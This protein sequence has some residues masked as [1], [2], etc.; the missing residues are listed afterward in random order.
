MTT[1]D[2]Q[3][4]PRAARSTRIPLYIS[5]GLVGLL[6]VLYFL[7]VRQQTEYFEKRNLRLL[8]GLTQQLNTAFETQEAVLRSWAGAHELP[9]A[10]RA[11]L[12]RDFDPVPCTMRALSG[13]DAARYQDLDELPGK[14]VVVRKLSYQ[15]GEIWLDLA[16]DGIIT[17]RSGIWTRP[18]DYV[19]PHE[20][21]VLGTPV[22]RK[23]ALSKILD[24]VMNR[25]IFGMFDSVFLASADG[26]VLYSIEPSHSSST[27]LWASAAPEH[28]LQ[29]GGIASGELMLAH[30]GAA[31]VRLGWRKSEPLSPSIL[32]DAGRK[33]PV[34]VSGRSYELFTQ[35][36]LFPRPEQKSGEPAAGDAWLVGG[37]VSSARLGADTRAVSATK[38]AFAIALCAIALCAWPFLQI[39]LKNERQPLTMADVILVS[40]CTVAGLMMLTL[41][42]L[43]WLTYMRL[44]DSADAQLRQFSYKLDRD[45]HRNLNDAWRALD[46]MEAWGAERTWADTQEAGLITA[47]TL[48]TSIYQ[49]AARPQKDSPAPKDEPPQKPVSAYPYFTSFALIDPQGMQRF[50]ASPGANEPL[51]DVSEREYFRK[52]LAR[53]TWDA[54]PPLSGAERRPYVLEWVRSLT[55]GEMRAVIAKPVS[56]LSIASK[57]PVAALTAELIDIRHS[58]APPGSGFA[59]ID[60]QGT[61]LYHSDEQRIKREDFFVETEQNRKLRAAVLGRTD[62]YVN[63]RYWGED[64]RMFVHPLKNT[65]WTLV[66]M[67]G[68]RLVRAINMEALLLTV[69]GLVFNGVPYLLLIGGVLAMKPWYRAAYL[70]PVVERRKTYARV[71]A[72]LALGIAAL[73]LS[74]YALQP[75]DLLPIL[76]LTPA[77]AMLSVYVLLHRQRYRKTSAIALGAWVVTTVLLFM[78]LLYVEVDADLAISRYPAR[79]RALLILI[80]LFASVVAAD[81]MTREDGRL[82]RRV[83][84]AGKDV[85]RALSE[86][87][88]VRALA[89]TLANGVALFLPAAEILDRSSL[90]L[91]GYAVLGQTG[92]SVVWVWLTRARRADDEPT[93]RHQ[94]IFLT[95]RI[96]WWSMTLALAAAI[97]LG[98][99]QAGESPWAWAASR[100]RS[101]WPRR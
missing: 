21:P 27:L 39:L 62:S 51:V 34:T 70:W 66:V 100:S 94:A 23:I 57:F 49:A 42:V 53:D 36:Y 88:H 56:H 64:Q 37:I 60:E 69:L 11:L 71:V 61:V 24:P 59:I 86:W 52:A 72:V 74:I 9:A 89:V 101:D 63:T 87:P 50:K 31:E 98:R 65:P 16:W 6:L 75:R 73:G 79:V 77:Q 76:A 84:Q 40:V 4:P 67:R 81:L 15:N 38:V 68:K 58:V 10:D 14:Q 17:H 33:T 32:R 83:D 46:A 8:A 44:S 47:A 26:R 19:P 92:V 96:A 18:A 28:A 22:C 5:L 99:V 95:C 13:D 2:T 3:A 43:D 7:Y 1:T 85:Q 93:P 80:S 54:A 20:E 78:A 25:D 90:E 48:P 35:P 41:T 55:T 12:L 91:L 97:A 30:L 29:R 82:R 45:F